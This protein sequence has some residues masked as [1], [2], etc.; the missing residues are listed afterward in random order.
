MINNNYITQVINQ[1]IVIRESQEKSKLF[2]NFDDNMTHPSKLDLEDSLLIYRKLYKICCKILTF[3][4]RSRDRDRE[5]FYIHNVYSLNTNALKKI[6]AQILQNY[7][8]SR[9]YKRFMNKVLHN[10]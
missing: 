9:G 2:T 10:F 5:N 4:L 7:F 1:E 3:L 8:M 6:V